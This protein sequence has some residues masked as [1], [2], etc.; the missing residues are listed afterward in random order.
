MAK[1]NYNSLRV[2]VIPLDYNS[3]FLAEKKE[4]L[5]D[6]TT[7]KLYVV[8]AE[9]KT[10]IHDITQNIMT[11]VQDGMDISKLTFNIEG[12]GPVNLSQYIKQIQKFNIKL[13]NESNKKY[14]APNV[15]FDNMSIVNFDGVVEVSGFTAAKNDTY[16]VKD[17]N[18][19][20]WVPRTD[21]GLLERVRVLEHN[22]PPDAAK[23]AQLQE[24]V[25]RVKLISDGYADVLNLRRDIDSNKQVLDEI[26]GEFGPLKNKVQNN[27]Q[28]IT[29][30][31]EKSTQYDTRILGLEAKEDLT[32]R[33]QT[34]E[35]SLGTLTAKEDLGPKLNALLQRIA[36]L[37]QAE[38][39]GAQI[40]AIKQNIT[41]M[42]DAREARTN[43]VDE[44]INNLIAYKNTNTAAMG[45]INDRLAAFD[46]I[47]ISDKLDRLFTRV[48]S[49]EAIPN[50]TKNISKLE[51]TTNT[52]TNSFNLIKG[53][54]DGLLNAEDPFPRIR[55]LE[56]K[57]TYRNNIPSEAYQN[58]AA[59]A[60]IEISPW[61]V[62][63]FTLQTGSPKFRIKGGPNSY[64]EYILALNPTNLDGK[65]FMISIIRPD[66]VEIKL[67]K[68]I[69]ASK[70]GEVQLVKLI[71][72]DSGVTWFYQV[73]PSFV[74]KD[75]LIDDDSITLSEA[76]GTVT[77]RPT[78]GRTSGTPTAT[79]GPSPAAS[80][81]SAGSTTSAATPSSSQPASGPSS[82][83][84]TPSATTAPSSQPAAGSS[85]VGD[86]SSAPTQPPASSHT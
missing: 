80:A 44:S 72:Y 71:T 31:T 11:Y 17:G 18:L 52:L 68:R 1:S 41:R 32:P 34:L 60:D 4:I 5:F 81:S 61:R 37:E 66:D 77:P 79:P 36:N 47:G 75:A 83:G 39:Y 9:D 54:V 67:P 23:F 13:L 58:L 6:Y 46:N 28:S 8:S 84:S 82:T 27:I 53:K 14:Y 55:T 30:L 43:S 33:V 69:I 62:Y 42:E 2:P 24:D 65:A 48:D 76:A 22:A 10:I 45:V 19:I 16:A 74:G 56:G 25:K 26:N 70:N 63:N 35:N 15:R 40:N 49:L 29:A 38:D 59:G 85:N 78:T 86:T 64:Q 73:A 50:F 7:G 51:S 57:E 21:T 12:I 20:K 3:R